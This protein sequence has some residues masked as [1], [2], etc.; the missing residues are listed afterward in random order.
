MSLHLERRLL[1]PLEDLAEVLLALP[2]VLGKDE[3]ERM[4]AD[5]IL[6]VSLR[7]KVIDV[8]DRAVGGDVHDDGGRVLDEQTEGL[9]GAGVVVQHD[10]EPMGPMS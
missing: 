8:E 6:D 10:S 9:I 4:L 3:L 2:M 1:A 7:R 5:D